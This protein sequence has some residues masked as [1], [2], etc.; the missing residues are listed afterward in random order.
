MR[1]TVRDPGGVAAL[2]HAGIDGSDAGPSDRAERDFL[3]AM[4]KLFAPLPVRRI[5]A[6]GTIRLT[7]CGRA[8]P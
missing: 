8:R 2:P 3:V 1:E 7:R 6:G 4:A 5:A